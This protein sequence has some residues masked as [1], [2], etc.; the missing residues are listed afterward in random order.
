MDNKRHK[1]KQ[2][3]KGEEYVVICKKIIDAH[4][5]RCG[6]ECKNIVMNLMG[7]PRVWTRIEFEC[8]ERI[9]VNCHCLEK[10]E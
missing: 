2:M 4:T 7:G 6:C 8:G 9:K 10:L 5:Y 1:K 3:H